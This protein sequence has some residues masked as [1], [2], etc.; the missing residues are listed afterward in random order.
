M[1]YLTLQY[2]CLRY[3]ISYDELG[4]LNL[5]NHDLLKYIPSFL[6]WSSQEHCMEMA[7]QLHNQTPVD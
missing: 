2:P 4:G 1:S 5:E 7:I 6:L 3:S